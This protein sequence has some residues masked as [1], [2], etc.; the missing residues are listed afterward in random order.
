M[1]NNFKQSAFVNLQYC[2][3][4]HLISRIVGRVAQCENPL[5]KSQFIHRFAKHYQVNMSEAEQPAL[6]QYPNFNAFFTR[7]LT[8][9]AR[10]IHAQTNSIICPADGV[11][12]Q[13]GNIASGNIIQ[14]K[15]M[16]YSALS[17]LGGDVDDAEPFLDG[18]FTTIYLAPKDYHRLHMPISGTLTKMIHIPGRLFSVNPTT[19]ESVPNLFARN[20]R[21]VA[22]FD[23]AIGPMALILVGA[24][25]VASIETIWHGIVTPPKKSTIQRWDYSDQ[26]IELEKG[27]EMGRF[28]LGSTIIA[29]FPKNSLQWDRST[30][31]NTTVRMGSPIATLTNN[32]LRT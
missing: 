18:D 7:A 16:H 32:T 24:M 9:N 4:H 17:L 2:L 3:P 29:L 14:A 1:P 26:S 27:A 8:A 30:H 25:I 13:V 20:E 21:V 28:R 23:T 31:E 15:G 6:D 19:A 22:L 12:S 10:P 5:I 11:I